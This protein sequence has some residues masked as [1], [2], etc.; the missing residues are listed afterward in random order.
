MRV[1][2]PFH[3]ILG[4]RSK[5]KPLTAELVAAILA[6][7]GAGES[8]RLREYGGA[9]PSPSGSGAGVANEA[10]R[11]QPRTGCGG[12]HGIERRNNCVGQDTHGQ[13]GDR[14]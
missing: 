14:V 11:Q 6:R 10:P 12:I 4:K 8:G 7:G 1:V 9:R 13:T 3:P 5:P 2:M